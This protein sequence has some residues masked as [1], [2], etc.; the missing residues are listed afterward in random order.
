LHFTLSHVPKPKLLAIKFKY[1]GDV[2][3]AVPALRALRDQWPDAELHALVAEDAAPLL[4]HL[5]WLDKVWALP[6]TR[7]KARLAESWPIIKKLRQEKFARS[8]DFVGNDRGALLSRLIGAK[9]RLGVMPV[10]GP[11]YRRLAYTRCIEEA[12]ATRHEIV[13]DLHVLSA[14]NVPFPQNPC[15]EIRADPALAKDAA[16]IF[17]GHPVIFHLST[18]QPKKEWPASNWVELYTRAHAAGVEIALSSGPSAREQ[19]LLAEV[20]GALPKAPT[21]PPGLPLDLFLA[22]V[23]RA[24]L[25]VSPDTAP[26]H[27]AAGLGIPTIGLFG[28][29][30]AS[31]WAPLGAQHQVVQGGLCSCSG[32]WHDC[33]AASPCMAAITPGAVWACI[34]KSL[35]APAP[36]PT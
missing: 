10:D 17:P 14:W 18:S 22:V 6:R 31:R 3:V 25:F 2:I 35:A 28:A 16:Q 9:E 15:L 7:G 29:T 23:A 26:L 1:L 27:L 5:P 11:Y 13:R 19:A 33:H 36:L 34:Q 21:V 32:H 8:V 24:Q 12:D 20:W 30:A 4:R